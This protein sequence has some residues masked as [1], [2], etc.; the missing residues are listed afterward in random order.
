MNTYLILCAIISLFPLLYGASKLKTNNNN[1]TKKRNR[2]KISNSLL[3]SS[4]FSEKTLNSQEKD[5]P[6]D[7][8][9]QIIKGNQK[10]DKQTLLHMR[11]TKK[12]NPEYDF[13]KYIIKTEGKGDDKLGEELYNKRG[14]SKHKKLWEDDKLGTKKKS[15]HRKPRKT[16][17]K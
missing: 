9:K 1:K 3:K 4:D 10:A 13:K 6:I 17:K 2:H 11:N 12:M 5:Y 7:I 14:W 8:Q 15:K 16:K